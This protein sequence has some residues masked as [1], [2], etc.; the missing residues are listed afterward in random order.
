MA[1]EQVSNRWVIKMRRKL[2]GAWVIHHLLGTYS[3]KEEILK[4][5]RNLTDRSLYS[6]VVVAKIP[7]DQWHAQAD[8][9][10]YN[11]RN[12]SIFADTYSW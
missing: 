1:T 2:D 12:H 6:K 9:S 5:N 4:F 10:V 7:K 11:V 8:S 3:S